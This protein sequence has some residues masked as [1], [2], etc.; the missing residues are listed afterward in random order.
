VPIYTTAEQSS[1]LIVMIDNGIQTCELLATRRSASGELISISASGVRR[2]IELLRLH[3]AG[4]MVTALRVPAHNAS[5]L[6]L[7][8]AA[9]WYL[10]STRLVIINPADIA[11]S[12]FNPI[13]IAPAHLVLRSLN[14]G[15]SIPGRQ[16]F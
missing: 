4:C 2:S 16:I 13:R 12:R 11:S 5:A 8:A 10:R 6:R 14:A 3:A 1:P 15:S 9:C 7:V